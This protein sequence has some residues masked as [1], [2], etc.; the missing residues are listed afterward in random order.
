MY[1]KHK[2]IE[3]KIEIKEQNIGSHGWLGPKMFPVTGSKSAAS[4]TSWTVTELDH[5]FSLTPG[6]NFSFNRSR[7]WEW[8][9]SERDGFWTLLFSPMLFNLTQPMNWFPLFICQNAPRYELLVCTFNIIRRH[10]SST[11]LET[12]DNKTPEAFWKKRRGGLSWMEVNYQ[13]FSKHRLV[14]LFLF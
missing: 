9:M 2:L 14:H 7:G 12:F 13:Y 3:T 6:T 1:S 8:M 10:R 5:T 4:Q 11:N